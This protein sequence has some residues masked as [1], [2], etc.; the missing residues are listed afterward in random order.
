MSE[1]SQMPEI[2]QDIPGNA[3]SV[4]GDGMDDFPVLKAFQHYIDAEQSKA[5]KR[6]LALCAVFGIVIA[7]V[8]AACAVI[9]VNISNRNQLL[10]DRLVEFAMK[11]RAASAVVVQPPQDNNATLLA[12][13]AKLDEMQ[14][15]LTDERIKADRAAAEAARIAA[16]AAK[17][18]GPT[19]EE[20]EIQRLNALLKAE[21]EKAAADAEKRKAE[22][23]AAQERRHQEELEA[24]RRKHY[25]ELYAPQA[26]PKPSVKPKRKV[27]IEE[28]DEDEDVLDDNSAISYFD[29]AEEDVEPVVVRRPRRSKKASPKKPDGETTPESKPSPKEYTIPVEVR[30]KSTSWSIPND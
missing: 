18:K 28:P 6:M 9:L 25:P 21:R 22:E 8:I 10:N 13:T 12:L 27:K 29:E 30:G 15:K 17:P 5:R 23:K 14:K 11:E 16:E 26:R 20:L 24:Y 4:Y 7:I 1:K 19:K 2:D 3:I